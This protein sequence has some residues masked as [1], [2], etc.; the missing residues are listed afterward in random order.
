MN[1]LKLIL[2]L[3]P[4][5]ANRAFKRSERFV[6]GGEDIYDYQASGIRRWN[7]FKNVYAKELT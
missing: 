4:S 2:S 7:V 3:F 1:G 5:D 6:I